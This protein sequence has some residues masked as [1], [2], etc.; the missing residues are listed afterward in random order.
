MVV[1]VPSAQKTHLHVL[2]VDQMD[3]SRVT[4]WSHAGHV[5]CM[6][7]FVASKRQVIAIASF[8]D[9]NIFLSIHDIDGELL[10]S[11]VVDSLNGRSAFVELWVHC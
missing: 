8:H 11:R 4:E 5:T 3:L 7:P 6:A 10:S 2:R 1:S 9:N